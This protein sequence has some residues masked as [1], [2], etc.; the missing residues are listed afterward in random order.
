MAW[1]SRRV[2]A[3]DGVE[4]AIAICFKP[5]LRRMEEILEQKHQELLERMGHEEVKN[6]YSTTEVLQAKSRS[7]RCDLRL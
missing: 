2:E 3:E 6:S 4:E 1:R 7:T 5:W